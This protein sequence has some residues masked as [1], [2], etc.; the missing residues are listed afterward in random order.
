ME[1]LYIVT[2]V[3]LALTCAFL[4][5]RKPAEAQESYKEGFRPF[6]NG[7]LM[8]YSLMMGKEYILCL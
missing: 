3:F 4:E 2:F 8:V 7:Y 6:R 1:A 5:Y